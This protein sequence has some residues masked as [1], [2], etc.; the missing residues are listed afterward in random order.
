MKILNI[1]T[2]WTAKQAGTIHEFLGELEAAVWQAYHENIQ[3]MHKTIRDN[4]AS[5]NVDCD[6]IDF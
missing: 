6:D 1:L 5:M 4:Q 3:Q 2:F